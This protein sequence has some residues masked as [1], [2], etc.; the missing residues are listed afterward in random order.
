MSKVA[1]IYL[2]IPFDYWCRLMN[3]GKMNKNWPFPWGVY[4]KLYFI[5]DDL[6][7][8]YK[9][10]TILTPTENEPKT[11]LVQV[12]PEFGW[13]TYSWFVDYKVEEK[14]FTYWIDN[15]QKWNKLNTFA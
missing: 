14:E 13:D 10:T 7:R 1:P 11:R 4:I 2:K 8:M 3:G 6:M 12:D 15:I 5:G 9:E